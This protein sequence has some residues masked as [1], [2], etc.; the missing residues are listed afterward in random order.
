MNK[1]L[2]DIVLTERV[3]YEQ[4]MLVYT[5]ENGSEPIRI[6]GVMGAAILCTM[7]VDTDEGN[8]RE[9]AIDTDAEQDAWMLRY[10]REVRR[11]AWGMLDR[12]ITLLSEAYIQ[13][14]ADESALFA[15]CP[16]ILLLDLAMKIVV[17]YMQHLVFESYGAHIWEKVRWEAPFARWLIDAAEIEPLRRQLLHTDWADYKAVIALDNDGVPDGQVALTFADEEAADIMQRYYQWAWNSYQAQLRE[18]PGAK[19]NSAHHKN[20]F[21]SEETAWAFFTD[22]TK[23]WDEEAR[24]LWKQWQTNWTDFLTHTLKPER[25]IL[26]WTKDVSEERQEQLLD[27]LRLQERQPMHYRCLTA[28]VYA[29]RQMGYI[30]RACSVKDQMRWLSRYL[31]YD[32]T[33]HSNSTQYNRAWKSHARYSADIRDEVKRLE[34]RGVHPLRKEEEDDD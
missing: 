15:I 23:D 31:S 26:F 29:L 24:K 32:Y 30:R 34:Q 3:R 18:V 10:E 2:E 12:E 16:N 7:L 27:Y 25:E 13:L 22:Q 9:I 33:T 28:A 20:D 14:T 4:H 8:R 21:L 19:V 6:S 1:M 11:H 17:R 5:P